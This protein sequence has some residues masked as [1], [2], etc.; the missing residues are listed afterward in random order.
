M[1]SDSVSSIILLFFKSMLWNLP[2]GLVV[3]TLP[4]NAGNVGSIPGQG[5]G[6]PHALQVGKKAKH[7]TNNTVTNSVLFF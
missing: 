4:S 5:A 6:T 7:E 3:S 1:N 2:G